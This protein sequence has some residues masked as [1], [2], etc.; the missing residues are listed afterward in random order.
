MSL[1]L[2]SN[3]TSGSSLQINS[4]LN[5][6]QDLESQ[7]AAEPVVGVWVLAVHDSLNWETQL[8]DNKPTIN[9]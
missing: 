6:W 1:T 9:E 3:S 2:K 7:Q 8:L 5:R 4:E